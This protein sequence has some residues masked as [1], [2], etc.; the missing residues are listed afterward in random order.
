MAVVPPWPDGNALAAEGAWHD[1]EPTFEADIVPRAG[2]GTHDLM[3]VVLDLRQTVRHCT[4]ARPIAAG[5][6]LL[7]QRLVRPIE[8]VQQGLRTPTGSFS[9]NCFIIGIRGSG[10]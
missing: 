9:E 1:P 3:P 2:D 7:A 8:I 10:C 4:R 6:H 5:R